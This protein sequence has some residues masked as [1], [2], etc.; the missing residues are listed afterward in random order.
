MDIFT[1]WE[2][3]TDISMVSLLHVIS[4][5][6][7]LSGDNALVI[8]MATKNLDK[9]LQNKAILIGVAGAII[10]RVLFASGIIFLLKLPFIYAIGGLLL[11]WI[12]Y[13]ITI[14]KEEEQQQ[15]TSHS[16]LHRAV[17][18]IILADVIM[19]L[20]NVVAIA[21]ASKGSIT[22]L[23]IGVLI[24]IPLMIYGAKF[25]VILLK[26][27]PLLVYGGSAILVYTGADMLI[28][29]SFV[30]HLFRLNDGFITVLLNLIIT[31]AVVFSGYI[32]NQQETKLN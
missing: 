4:I 25:I 22:L 24:S 6:I 29:D 32:T 20:D 5:D 26:K 27:F 28:H 12:G 16:S 18:T 10:L 13:K 8:A 2:Q 23:T 15:V 21:G 19:S 31:F 7:V 3:L 1:L 30:F 9:K 14:K 17:L 11:I